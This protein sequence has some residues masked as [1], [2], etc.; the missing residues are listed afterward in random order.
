MTGLFILKAEQGRTK[1]KRRKKDAECKHTVQPD[2][3]NEKISRKTDGELENR[4][5]N[6]GFD[7]V[8]SRFFR[9]EIY[10]RGCGGICGAI[11]WWPCSDGGRGAV[12]PNKRK[13]SGRVYG[14]RAYDDTL[15]EMEDLAKE[16]GFQVIA[17]VAAV[18]EHSIAHQ[19]AAGRP[20]E[21]DTEKLHVFGEQILQKIQRGERSLKERIPGN[22]PYREAG[23]GG[24]IP[25]PSDSCVKCGICAAKCPVHA[26]DPGDSA[27]IQEEKCISCMGCT[28]VC[29]HGARVLHPNALAVVSEKLKEVCSVRKECELVS[30]K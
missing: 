15:V 10:R 26:I 12:F 7:D 8:W 28:A 29:P 13:W 24:M 3:R 19:Y 11:F 21:M 18:A 9:R 30:A 16:C 2:R 14:N 17:A 20:D 23:G 6:D 22:H 25:W 5:G 27:A 4:N 1:E